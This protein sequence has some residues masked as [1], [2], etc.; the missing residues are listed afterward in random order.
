MK[1]RDMMTMHH[2]RRTSIQHFVYTVRLLQRKNLLTLSLNE[3]DVLKQFDFH[4]MHD[5]YYNKLQNSF[6]A[7]TMQ[8]R[9]HNFLKICEKIYMKEV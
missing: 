8:E 7:S 4:N 1:E 5:D 3:E 6:L 9:I 2:I